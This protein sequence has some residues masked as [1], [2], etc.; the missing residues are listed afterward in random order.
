M[1]ALL[2]GH[3]FQSGEE[4][5]AFMKAEINSHG[6]KSAGVLQAVVWPLAEMYDSRRELLQG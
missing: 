1:K 4:G 3:I 5:K 2:K 6:K